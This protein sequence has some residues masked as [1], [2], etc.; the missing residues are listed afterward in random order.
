M[1]IHLSLP[2]A[3]SRLDSLQIRATTI[4]DYTVK[5]LKYRIYSYAFKDNKDVKRSLVVSVFCV[6]VCVFCV[7]SVCSPCL[8]QILACQQ[9]LLTYF[10]T[11]EKSGR[12]QMK[13]TIFLKSIVNIIIMVYTL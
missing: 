8:S 6:C 5:I 11:A 4:R 3:Y 2:L 12:S 9:G 10:L 7:L 13:L 1:H